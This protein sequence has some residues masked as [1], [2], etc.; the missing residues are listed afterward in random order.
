MNMIRNK[1]RHVVT[2]SGCHPLIALTTRA[3][4]SRVI[5]TVDTFTT[6]SVCGRYGFT[7]FIVHVGPGRAYRIESS[8]Y[9]EVPLS[10]SEL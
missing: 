5:S 6:S 7:I 8:G 9:D 3:D 1:A 10:W 4:Y 2:E